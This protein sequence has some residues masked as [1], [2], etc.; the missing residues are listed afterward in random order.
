[1]DVRNKILSKRCITKNPKKI[2]VYK[3]LMQKIKYSANDASLKI[4]IKIIDYKI[5]M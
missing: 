4:P 5:W 3:I 2:I 1:M